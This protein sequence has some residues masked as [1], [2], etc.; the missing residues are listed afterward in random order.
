MI[1]VRFS[2]APAGYLSLRA[3][4]VALANALFGLRYG[5]TLQLRIDDRDPNRS[6][7]AFVEALL[8]DL[9]WLGIE[10]QETI[11]QSERLGVYEAAAERLKAAGRLYPCF[12]SADE[13]RFKQEQR[14]KQGK[15]TVYDRSMLSLTAA[16]RAAAEANGKHPYWRFRLSDRMVTWDDLVA[17]RRDAKLQAVSDPVVIDAQGGFVGLFA[18]VVD[19]IATGV[20]HV[21]H[22]EDGVGNIAIELDLF[23]ALGAS[24]PIL[25]Q[26]P[27]LTDDPAQRTRRR[28]ESMS[29]RSLRA[30]GIEPEALAAILAGADTVEEGTAGASLAALAPSFELPRNSTP[31]VFDAGRL[32]HL[33]RHVL[34]AAPFT[35]VAD[36]LPPGATEAFW[37]AIRGGID[38]LNEARGW[39]DV[40][41][42]TIVPPVM[43][44]QR[45]V[46]HAAR[47][48]LPE[49]PW[50][51]EVLTGWLQRLA[52]ATGRE[53][54]AL[55]EA[56]RLA[57]TGEDSGPDLD[58]LL[59]LIGRA[60]ANNRLL[61]AVS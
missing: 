1:R 60:R 53:R 47:D 27:A 12:E 20:T 36:R 44:E 38:L 61:I 34:A 35:R 23:A 37:L 7:P 52:Q 48:T 11:R 19:D 2:T 3:A 45:D 41:A 4:K 30:D 22:G 55:V 42:G 14:R 17:G 28:V 21:I 25:A 49:E 50:G 58:R 6:R 40:V 10:P 39:W 18:A 57:M 8:Q 31:Q 54:L 51:P 13:L 16:Q 15:P 46:L 56:L 24:A 59:P 9:H 29:V 43:P 32:L 26:L 5:G 33:N